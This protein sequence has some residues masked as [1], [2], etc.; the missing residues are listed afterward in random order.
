MSNV[1]YRELRTVHGLPCEIK[2]CFGPN[3]AL[4]LCVYVGMVVNREA[5]S[6]VRLGK[7]YV[8]LISRTYDLVSK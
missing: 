8:R 3:N 4:A 5:K 7:S 2:C 1:L 6:Y